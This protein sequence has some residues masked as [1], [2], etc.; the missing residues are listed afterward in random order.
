MSA[1]MVVYNYWLDPAVVVC[2][3]V[4][5]FRHFLRN[6]VSG[7]QVQEMDNLHADILLHICVP[8]TTNKG[9]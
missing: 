6:H 5:S 2:A 4:G 7:Y 8:Y 1:T 3:G 9:K